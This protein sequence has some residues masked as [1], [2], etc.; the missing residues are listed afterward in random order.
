MCDVKQQKFAIEFVIAGLNL[1]VKNRERWSQST[2]DSL[3]SNITESFKNC[4]KDSTVLLAAVCIS[5]LMELRIDNIK[6]GVQ[7]CLDLLH[8]LTNDLNNNGK[9]SVRESVEAAQARILR[10]MKHDPLECTMRLETH[11]RA[12]KVIGSMKCGAELC[13]CWTKWL[14]KVTVRMQ[15][16]VSELEGPP[17]IGDM[18]ATNILGTGTYGAAI[19]VVIPNGIPGALDITTGMRDN[20]AVLK[21][22]TGQSVDV[23]K[24]TF[25]TA[26]KLY[27]LRIGPAVYAMY[28]GILPDSK[29][30]TMLLMEELEGDMYNIMKS[31]IIP[32]NVAVSALHS[33]YDK[34]RDAGVAH[35][36]GHF[37]NVGY[38]I[39]PNEAFRLVFID[40]ENV[41]EGSGKL[42]DVDRRSPSQTDVRLR[43][44]LELVSLAG[45]MHSLAYL[46]T[47]DRPSLQRAIYVHKFFLRPR[48]LAMGVDDPWPDGV[49]SEMFQETSEKIYTE[50]FHRTGNG[51]GANI[52]GKARDCWYGKYEEGDDSDD[53]DDSYTFDSIDPDRTVSRPVSPWLSAVLPAAKRKRSP[54]PSA[55]L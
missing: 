55:I 33:L 42:D 29:T 46:S 31:S 16:S 4:K 3:V 52:A 5:K 24:S 11:E 51:R 2:I 7:E 28:H 14:E 21:V 47:Y 35:G 10:E 8:F 15:K 39:R 18:N 13:D 6:E 43:H 36:D 38:I 54:G 49:A 1:I 9:E 27:D 26:C 20:N 25:K 19:R 53:S 37:G 45:V 32:M 40:P 41:V 44:S 12:A 23:L 17:R 34:A 50:F 30:V 22:E 48:L